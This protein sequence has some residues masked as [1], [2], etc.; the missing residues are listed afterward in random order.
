MSTDRILAQLLG[1]GAASGFAGALAGGPITSQAGRRLGKTALQVGGIEAEPRFSRQ[2]AAAS[3]IAPLEPFRGRVGVLVSCGAPPQ[4]GAAEQALREQWQL[5]AVH[6]LELPIRSWTEALAEAPGTRS[7]LARYAMREIHRRDPCLV[8][9]LDGSAPGGEPES[10]D[11]R[12]LLTLLRRWGATA[13]LAALRARPDGTVTWL[14]APPL[15]LRES[16]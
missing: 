9:I 6:H 11:V 14:A 4:R 3:R 16:G 8:A 7:W 10:R 1:S 15:L 2:I 12:G 5:D 13:P